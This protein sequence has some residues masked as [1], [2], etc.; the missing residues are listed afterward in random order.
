MTFSNDGGLVPGIK[1]KGKWQNT[2]QIK[3][4]S[5]LFTRRGL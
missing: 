4:F 1:K 2:G 5:D 3:L